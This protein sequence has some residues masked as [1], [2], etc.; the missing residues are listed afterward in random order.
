MFSYN[1]C[2]KKPVNEFNI[3]MDTENS[4]SVQPKRWKP[5]K[6]GLNDFFLSLYNIY[7]FVARF[8][9]EVFLPPYEWNE[10]VR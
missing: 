2:N 3:L 8:F 7:L 1:Y 6:R 5:F 10:V 9:K 4:T